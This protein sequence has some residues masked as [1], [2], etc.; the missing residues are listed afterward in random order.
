MKTPRDVRTKSDRPILSVIKD[1]DPD[2]NA[3]RNKQLEYE[4][5]SGRKFYGR[6]DSRGPYSN[7]AS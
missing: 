3:D 4:F 5:S 2:F 7:D 1:A 6:P